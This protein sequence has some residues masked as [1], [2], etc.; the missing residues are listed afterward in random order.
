M[1]EIHNSKAKQQKSTV[2]TPKFQPKLMIADEHCL[3][4]P[5]DPIIM[6]DHGTK[7]HAMRGWEVEGGGPI[8]P[9]QEKTF[10]SRGNIHNVR[11]PLWREGE[12]ERRR[13]M[14]TTTSIT[15]KTMR[16]IMIMIIIR[17]EIKM[18]RVPNPPHERRGCESVKSVGEE[19]MLLHTVK[20]LLGE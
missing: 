19:R 3:K 15:N 11:I 20:V 7:T 2:K 18:R 9:G 17:I 4:K 12:R 13:I 1:T 10:N 5:T 6:L 8:L 14:K 16:I